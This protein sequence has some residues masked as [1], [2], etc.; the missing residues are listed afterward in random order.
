M[1]IHVHSN[2]MCKCNGWATMKI[3]RKHLLMFSY[4]RIDL[5]S[6]NITN[7]NLLDEGYILLVAI[8]TAVFNDKEPL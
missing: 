1:Y 8:G 2:Y 6:A 3:C 5:Y 7:F 4:Y